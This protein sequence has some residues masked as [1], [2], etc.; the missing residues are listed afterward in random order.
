MQTAKGGFVH[1]NHKKIATIALIM[2]AVFFVII[3]IYP[4]M[5]NSQ[6][7]AAPVGESQPVV[8][9]IVPASPGAPITR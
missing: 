9:P 1:W 4:M 8:S 7:V 3:M 6:K 2:A 5:F